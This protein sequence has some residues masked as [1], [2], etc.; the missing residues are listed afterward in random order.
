MGGREAADM[1]ARGA[2]VLRPEGPDVD[3]DQA[4]QLADE[5]LDVDA[6]TAVD[7]RRV[8]VGQDQGSHR[9]TRQDARIAEIP[10]SGVVS[11]SGRLLS[12]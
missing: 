12:S 4:G 10:S 6:R 1:E 2:F 7:V 5:V 11:H 3:V 8:L 9:R